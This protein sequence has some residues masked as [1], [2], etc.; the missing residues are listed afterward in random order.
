[1]GSFQCPLLSRPQSTNCSL[2]SVSRCIFLQQLI[3]WRCENNSEDFQTVVENLCCVM[4]KRSGFF[5]ACCVENKCMV[6]ALF[7]MLG[8]SSRKGKKRNSINEDGCHHQACRA[9]YLNV[10]NMFSGN[11]G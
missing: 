10:V 4:E 9:I 1:M 7:V 5:A 3:S 11:F 8:Q 6:F 2:V